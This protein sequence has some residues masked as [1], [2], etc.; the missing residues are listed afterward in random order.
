M[1]LKDHFKQAG[2][3]VRADIAMAPDGSSKGYG[4]VLSPPRVRP[5]GDPALQRVQLS[6]AHPRRARTLHP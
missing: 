4:T 3:V 6:G 2:N 1:E 5:Q